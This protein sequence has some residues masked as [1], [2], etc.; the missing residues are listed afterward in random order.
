MIDTTE[1]TS[2]LSKDTP[3]CIKQ[4]HGSFDNGG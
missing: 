1:L 4:L 2:S 3:L